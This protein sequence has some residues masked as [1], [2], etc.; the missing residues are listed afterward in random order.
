[1]LPLQPAQAEGVQPGRMVDRKT[2]VLAVEQVSELDFSAWV[3]PLDDPSLPTV[4]VQDSF[5]FG[6][7][8]G[9]DYQL[10]GV[11]PAVGGTIRLDSNGYRLEGRGARGEGLSELLEDGSRF[12]L[13]SLTFLFKVA[14]RFAEQPL[15]AARLQ[16]LDGMDQGRSLALQ[17]GVAYPIGA[18]SSCAL[19]VR[20]EGVGSRHA[21]ALYKQRSCIVADLGAEGGVWH[22][23][24][25]VGQRELASGEEVRLGKVRLLYT[26]EG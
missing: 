11:E 7:D 13:G 25:Q 23:N 16:V 15:G 12:Q 3:V 22:R 1:M 9:C 21:V 20:G 18:H 10:S 2:Q 24:Q 6:S 4:V 17:D 26:L 19:V 5:T 14:R 8:S